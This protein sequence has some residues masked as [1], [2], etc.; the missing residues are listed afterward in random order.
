M[1]ATQYLMRDKTNSGSLFRLRDVRFRTCAQDGNSESGC[2]LASHTH[3]PAWGDVWLSPAT[4]KPSS[5]S[6][7]SPVTASQ[8]DQ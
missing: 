3:L 7:G 1:T 5:C 2:G 4:L 6:A 8:G